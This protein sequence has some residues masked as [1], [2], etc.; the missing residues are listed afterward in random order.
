MEDII[1]KLLER[2]KMWGIKDCVSNN[3]NQ[4]INNQ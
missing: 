1:K 3:N 2:K 4:L